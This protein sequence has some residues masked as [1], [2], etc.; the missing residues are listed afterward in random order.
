MIKR[1]ILVAF[2][3][4]LTSCVVEPSPINYGTDACHFCKMTIVDKVHASEIVTKKGKI[5]K[6]DAIECMIVFLNDFDNSK[7]QL[8]L[9]NNYL[10]PVSLIDATKATFLISKNISSPMGAFLSAF[11][12]KAAAEKVKQNKGGKLFNWEEIQHHLKDKQ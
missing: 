12:S 10:E 3:F 6:F 8:F 9:S 5:Y 2:I 11:N 1:F 4:C 7:V